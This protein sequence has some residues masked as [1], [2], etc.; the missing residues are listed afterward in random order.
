MNPSATADSHR[1]NRPSATGIAAATAIHAAP[2]AYPFA[3]VP[4]PTGF[5]AGGLQFA[6]AVTA[7]SRANLLER[8]AQVVALH[9]ADAAVSGIALEPPLDPEALDLGDYTAEGLEAE[10]VY[11]R[12][13]AIS[14]ASIAIAR[15]LRAEGVTAAELARRLGVARS[16]VSRLTD[17]LYFGHST[18]TLRGVATALNRRLTIE[19]EPA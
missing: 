12:P 2:D 1:S 19:L 16:V 11:V 4:T 15:A 18:R 5:S 9:V 6:A 3:L 14:D 8:L 7:P 17:P 13:A 10:V